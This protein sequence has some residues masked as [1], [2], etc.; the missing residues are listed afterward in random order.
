MPRPR[1]IGRARASAAAP[2]ARSTRSRRASRRCRP[3][4]PDYG[5]W[6]SRIWSAAG[7][8]ARDTSPPRCVRFGRVR[9]A[10]A[11]NSRGRRLARRTRAGSR[12]RARAR[13]RARGVARRRRRRR[14]RG[15][16][17]RRRGVAGVAAAAGGAYARWR[18][19]TNSPEAAMSIP[20]DETGAADGNVQMV[21]GPGTFGVAND[22]L[23][24]FYYEFN[25][26]T[27]AAAVIERVGEAALECPAA[28]TSAGHARRG[29]HHLDGARRAHA[30]RQHERDE[31]DRGTYSFGWACSTSR[32]LADGALPTVVSMRRLSST[33][34]ASCGPL[35]T[36]RRSRGRLRRVRWRSSGGVH[37]RRECAGRHRRRVSQGTGGATLLGATGDGGSHFSLAFPTRPVGRRSTASRAAP[38]RR[39][40]RRRRGSSASAARMGSANASAA[41]RVLVRRRAGFSWQ[42]R[43]VLAGRGCDRVPRFRATAAAEPFRAAARR[44]GVAAL[45]SG[46]PMVI[47]GETIAT[48]GAARRAGSRA[49]SRS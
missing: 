48:G 34:P 15:P 35:Q 25:V 7:S 33:T 29:V 31:H 40:P 19:A 13:P 18:W 11:T 28:I 44:P 10:I 41:A 2:R 47:G 32:S 5:Q 27:S 3:A 1:L 21:W 37:V 16:G 45:A 30:R 36:R 8:V 6:L 42:F 14:H 39:T 4:A 12:V 17:R 26:S 22:D 23:N 20:L 43:G 24:A 38:C 49:S 46:V 9:G